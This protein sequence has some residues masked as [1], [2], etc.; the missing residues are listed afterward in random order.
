MRG[1]H[2]SCHPLCTLRQGI[3][4]PLSNS[5]GGRF[6]A[7]LVGTFSAFR[8][9]QQRC[10]RIAQGSDLSPGSR[11]SGDT[12]MSRSPK[13]AIACAEPAVSPPRQHRIP[14]WHRLVRAAI[15]EASVLEMESLGLIAL[16]AADVLVTYILLQTRAR[17]L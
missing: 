4:S 12:N 15:G 11:A 16:S 17:V 14:N 10:V 13:Q 3:H 9:F 6:V 8:Y 5:A 1:E 7:R 2:E